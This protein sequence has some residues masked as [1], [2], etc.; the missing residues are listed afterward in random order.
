MAEAGGSQH[1]DKRQVRS[2]IHK[3]GLKND[4]SCLITDGSST[5]TASSLETTPIDCYNVKV[6]ETETFAE[7]K[8]RLGPV[9]ALPHPQQ[10]RALDPSC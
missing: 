9:A 3:D 1:K 10:G 4:S 2:R 8:A 7:A 5:P 6:I